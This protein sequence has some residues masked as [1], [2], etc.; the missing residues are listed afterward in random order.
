MPMGRPKADL[1]LDAAERA[2]CNRWSTARSIP[3]AALQARAQIMLASASREPNNSV[4]RRL[5]YR[6]AT[7][8]KW[9]RR[10]IER[11]IN[12]LY[13]V[14]RPGKPR[15]IDAERGAELIQTTLH[16]KPTDGATR[17]SIRSVAAKTGIWGTSLRRYIKLFGS[18]PHRSETFTLSTDAFF[19]EKL[20]DVV[21]LHLNPP[22]RALVLCVDEKRQ[23]QALERTQPLLPMGFGYVEGITHD[24]K[25]RGTTTLFAALDV[26]TGQ[27]LAQC[28]PG[29]RNFSASCAPSKPRCRR[30]STG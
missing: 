10:F 5:D 6:N 4:A 29:P 28:K 12:G 16:R 26:L 20:R 13:D 22:D 19:N 21:G 23:V 24:Y 7:V 18:Q 2:P 3:A 25:R 27:V 14:L 1:V 9:R 11:R 30:I 8:G 15:S 17:W